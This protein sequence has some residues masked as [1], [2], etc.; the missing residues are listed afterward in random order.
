[1][2]DILGCMAF[3]PW[4]HVY[5]KRIQRKNSTYLLVVQPSTD[6]KPATMQDRQTL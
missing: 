5:K 1:M 3:D 4:I 6:K 2:L